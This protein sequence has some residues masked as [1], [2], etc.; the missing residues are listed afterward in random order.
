MTN[1]NNINSLIPAGVITIGLAGINPLPNPLPD[2]A[3]A[4]DPRVIARIASATPAEQLS[5]GYGINP[6]ENSVT[7]FSGIE[8]LKEN[9]KLDLDNPQTVENLYSTGYLKLSNGQPFKV[10]QRIS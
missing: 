6:S 1:P 9:F 5:V 4:I 8:S 2:S 7:Q 3:Y 10:I